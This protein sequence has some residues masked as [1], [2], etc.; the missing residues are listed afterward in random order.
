VS[1]DAAAP[2]VVAL[3]P[4][5]DRP[6]LAVGMIVQVELPGYRTKRQQAVVDYVASQVVGPDEARRSLGDPIGDAL[7][8]QGP[9]VIVRAHLTT[10]TFEAEGR[11]YELHDGMLG[12]AEI[13]VDHKSLLRTLLPM[14]GE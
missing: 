11:E 8:I 5:F 4:G 7:P 12:K 13:K 9:V 3:M 10:R 14:G 6:R 2:S 1:A